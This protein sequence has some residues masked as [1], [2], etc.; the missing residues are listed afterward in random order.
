MDELTEAPLSQYLEKRQQEHSE[1]DYKGE[2]KFNIWQHPTILDI[3]YTT[4]EVPEID[5]HQLYREN[6]FEDQEAQAV[7]FL[8][9]I[10]QVND[11]IEEN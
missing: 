3:P 6:Y 8:S 2:E 11:V 7:N 9:N 5:W 10:E 1:L 4:E